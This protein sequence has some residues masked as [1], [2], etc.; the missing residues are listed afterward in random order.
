MDLLNGWIDAAK[1]LAQNAIKDRVDAASLGS[2]QLLLSIL[3][4]TFHSLSEEKR[5]QLLQALQSA[6]TRYRSDQTAKDELVRELTQNPLIRDLA[7]SVTER[8]LK[9]L[10][11]KVK[12]GG[13]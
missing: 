11:N 6:L 4:D 7:G 1:Q 3:A 2:G 13:T 5:Q 10:L 9:A 8:L 12:P